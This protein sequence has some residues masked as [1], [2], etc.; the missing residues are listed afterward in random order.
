[1]KRGQNAVVLHRPTQIRSVVPKELSVFRIQSV[2]HR[3]VH[4]VSIHYP[5]AVDVPRSE[6]GTIVQMVSVRVEER[7]LRDVLQRVWQPA[8]GE[9]GDDEE[10]RTEGPLVLPVLIVPEP[11]AAAPFRTHVV[12]VAVY[13]GVDEHVQRDHD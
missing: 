13:L 2:V 4:S 8:N 6:C 12:L 5:G 9:G 3:A 11:I 7:Q 1:M 10:G